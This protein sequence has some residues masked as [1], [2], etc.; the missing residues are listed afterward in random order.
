VVGDD[1]S[2]HNLDDEP[3]GEVVGEAAAWPT[4]RRLVNFR[5]QGCRPTREQ[6]PSHETATFV[7]IVFD[8]MIPVFF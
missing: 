5:G 1:G 2:G 6:H 7:G 3:V 8:R 4:P